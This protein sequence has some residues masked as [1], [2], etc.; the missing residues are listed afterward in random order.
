MGER[1]ARCL[2]RHRGLRSFGTRGHAQAPWPEAERRA[3]APTAQTPASPARRTRA[4][5][6]CPRGGRWGSRRV[7]RLV[8]LASQEPAQHA[9]SDSGRRGGA[10]GDRLSTPRMSTPQQAVLLYPA[11]RLERPAQWRRA[12]HDQQGGARQGERSGAA[13]RW[14]GHAIEPSR[15]PEGREAPAQRPPSRGP[16]RAAT[17]RCARKLTTRREA[18]RD[19]SASQA[20]E[21]PPAGTCCGRGTRSSN[22]YLY[23]PRSPDGRRRSSERGWIRRGVLLFPVGPWSH[24]LA[25]PA[26]SPGLEGHPQGHRLTVSAQVG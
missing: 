26:L 23:Q 19:T 20:P 16:A 8:R 10:A 17:N 4:P 21:R 2:H 6:A 25:A 3:S 11:T 18:H 22:D 12:A 15:V 24:I 13:T 14:P 7:L 9:G 5:G 1:R